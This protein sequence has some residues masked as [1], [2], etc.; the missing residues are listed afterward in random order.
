MTRRG[1][2]PWLGVLLPLAVACA[3]PKAGPI[4]GVRERV[5]YGDPS[6]MGGAEDAVLLL[7]TT[8]DGGELLCSASLVAKNLALT[9]RHCVARVV[10]GPFNCTPRGELVDNP[11][12]AGRIGADL[13]ADSIEFYGG[14]TPR[15]APLARGKKLISTLSSSVC[16]NDV[17]FVVLDRDVD[18]APLALRLESTTHVGEEMVLVGYGLTES[19][20]AFIDYRSQP[21]LRKPGLE[22]ADIGPDSIDEGVTSVAPRTLVLK[23]PS[24]CVADSGGPLLSGAGAVVGVYSLLDGTSC[25]DRDVR[26][27]FAHVP[28]FRGLIDQAFEAARATAVPERPAKPE[29]GGHRDAS[30]EPDR[31]P[32]ASSGCGAAGRRAPSAPP[33]VTSLLLAFAVRSRH[34]TAR[35]RASATPI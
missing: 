17:A 22:I 28:P 6:P 9:A 16:L 21:R 23:G 27:D 5:V 8:I 29:D 18:I 30:A 19:Q 10:Q 35:S 14:A 20:S 1:D 26:N 34:R 15:Q 11:D 12:A 7:R 24:A 32:E 33:V 31:Q 25:V 4:G 13:P 2:R 3:G